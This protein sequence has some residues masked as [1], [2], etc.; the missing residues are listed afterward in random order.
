MYRARTCLWGRLVASDCFVAFLLLIALLRLI[1]L[2]LIIA[3]LFLAIDRL[4]FVVVIVLDLHFGSNSF[5]FGSNAL[6][7]ELTRLRI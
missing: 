1:A 5:H 2:L 4:L 3:L 7:L 6:R